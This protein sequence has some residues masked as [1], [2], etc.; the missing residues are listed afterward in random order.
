MILKDMSNEELLEYKSVL[1]KKIARL[2]NLQ[3]AKKV[4]L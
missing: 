3:T 4:C 1:T 2:N